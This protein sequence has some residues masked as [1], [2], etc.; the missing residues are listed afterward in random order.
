MFSGK[1]ER[2]R[3]VYVPQVV[4]FDPGGLGGFSI[5]DSSAARLVSEGC[6]VPHPAAQACQNPLT[7][8]GGS[9]MPAS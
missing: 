2:E 4:L 9:K 7:G 5:E 1:N 8:L 6:V 3:G